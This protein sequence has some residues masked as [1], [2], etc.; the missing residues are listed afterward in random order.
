MC[1]FNNFFAI[2]I[3]LR[4]SAFETTVS[5][6]HRKTNI[7]SNYDSSIPQNSHIFSLSAKISSNPKSGMNNL[8][9]PECSSPGKS[10]VNDSGL[11]TEKKYIGISELYEEILQAKVLHIN[12]KLHSNHLI[13]LRKIFSLFINKNIEFIFC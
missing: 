11:K 7:I 12:N 10:L 8:T 3:R 9:F 1:S 4:N 2:G 5:I 13:S 6:S